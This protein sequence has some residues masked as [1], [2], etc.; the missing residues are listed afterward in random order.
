MSAR[1]AL[2]AL[3]HRSLPRVL[4]NCRAPPARGRGR[5][6]HPK[7]TPASPAQ[8]A[9]R[10]RRDAGT[11]PSP[12]FRGPGPARCVADVLGPGPRSAHCARKSTYFA[13]SPGSSRPRCSR[14]WPQI[15]G[16]PAGRGGRVGGTGL[17][18]TRAFPF[19]F[20][21]PPAFLLPTLRGGRTDV[22]QAPLPL[23]RGRWPDS[24]APTWLRTSGSRGKL[25]ANPDARAAAGTRRIPR[26]LEGAQAPG[27]AGRTPVAGMRPTPA[28][29]RSGP[30]HWPL[31]LW[32]LC[33]CPPGHLVP[34]VARQLHHWDWGLQRDR[35]GLHWVGVCWE[36]C[37]SGIRPQHQPE[38]RSKRWVG[39]LPRV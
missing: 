15:G 6:P 18:G 33:T 5:R 26:G 2:P 4:R 30:M 3:P 34:R 35:V 14:S 21:T 17:H 12:R 11:G 36:C 20:P 22:K 9:R 1:H 8:R 37:E 24:A 32:R 27:S 25:P 29:L 23:P 38:G 13:R 28:P 16:V 10:G 7:P 31:Q 19:I 39:P